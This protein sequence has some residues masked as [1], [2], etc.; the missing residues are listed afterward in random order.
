MMKI[1]PAFFAFVTTV[2]LLFGPT[3]QTMA[4]QEHQP[5][6]THTANGVSLVFDGMATAIDQHVALDVITD[7][8]IHVVVRPLVHTV[9]PSESLIVVDS[10]RRTAGP[11]QLE[12]TMTHVLLNTSV[13]TVQVC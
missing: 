4:K 3:V 6:I 8:I 2:S 11:W 12:E 13:L 5:K 9:E 7:G 1:R 10:L